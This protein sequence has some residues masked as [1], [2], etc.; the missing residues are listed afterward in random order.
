MTHS[1]KPRNRAYRCLVSVA[2][3]AA[4][5]SCANEP[6]PEPGPN[7]AP[8]TRTTATSNTPDPEPTDDNPSISLPSLPIGGDA[9]ESSD[10]D[11]PNNQCVDV[12]WIVD[13]DSEATLKAGIEIE[14]TSFLFTPE[15]FVV[16]DAGCDDSN[17]S[18]TGFVFTE[19]AQVCNLAV[20][21]AEGAEPGTEATVGLTG[22]V[23]CTL[24]TEECEAFAD[25]AEEQ[26]PTIPLEVPEVVPTDETSSPTDELT[27]TSSG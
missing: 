18:C 1:T 17:P 9:E 12:N 10:S 24:E 5:V 8:T 26:N 21:P 11:H 22:I 16:S 6:D 23:T 14:V 20:E 7:P 19:D 13:E 27:D 3:L 15:I 25:S 2:L 4:L